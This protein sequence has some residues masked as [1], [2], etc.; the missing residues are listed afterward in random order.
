MIDY[1]NELRDGVLEAYTGIVQG[2]RGDN[3]TPGA[4]SPDL[5]LLEPHVPHIVELIKVIAVD[6]DHTDP[7][8]A[9]CA[10]LVG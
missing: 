3:P 2:L 7:N 6:P 1:L 4:P 9:N 8:I 10:G 5:A